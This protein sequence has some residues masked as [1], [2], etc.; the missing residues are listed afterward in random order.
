VKI[1][2]PIQF[3]KQIEEIIFFERQQAYLRKGP[4]GPLNLLKKQGETLPG[5]FYMGLLPQKSGQR[6]IF[7]ISFKIAQEKN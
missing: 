7:W 3:R 6:R 5:F 1:G 2:L 4:H